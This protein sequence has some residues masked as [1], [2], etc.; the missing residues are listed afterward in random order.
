MLKLLLVDDEDIVLDSLE[1]IITKNFTDIQLVGSAYTGK[2]AIEMVNQYKPDIIFM[3]INMPGINGLEAIKEIRDINSNI[4][5]IIISAYDFF[6]YAKQAIHLKVYDY[7]LK[8][9]NKNEVIEVL[10]KGINKL[11]AEI[12]KK[13]NELKLREKVNEILPIVEDKLAYLLIYKKI[14][15]KNLYTYQ[16]VLDIDFSSGYAFSIKIENLPTEQNEKN[17]LIE[18]LKM[19]VNSLCKCIIGQVTDNLLIVFVALDE[20]YEEDTVYIKAMDIAKKL[21]KHFEDIRIGIGNAYK[22]IENLY[23]TYEDASKAVQVTSRKCKV[24][25]YIDITENC[26]FDKKE[27]DYNSIIEE[28]YLGNSHTSQEKF[29]NY[30]RNIV[31]SYTE[32]SIIKR[33]L[34]EFLIL[35]FSI[36]IKKGVYK[37]NINNQIDFLDDFFMI[38]DID[39]LYDWILNQVDIIAK[40]IYETNIREN[41]IITRAKKI[42]NTNYYKD[43]TL[44][45]SR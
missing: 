9:I 41:S 5:I 24:I 4:L 36:A 15:D 21:V 28:I 1:Y 23:R 3:D 39:R 27:I 18:K 30:F 26:I 16:R 17:I 19:I 13:S 14:K 22:G 34:L 31:N 43:I 7:L 10:E 33:K 25:H 44:E 8:P 37:K 45:S 20:L 32:I 29:V 11:T 42:I 40:S 12:E 35:M 38:D 6:E 2:Q